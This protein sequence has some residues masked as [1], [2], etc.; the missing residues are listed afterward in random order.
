MGGND[1]QLGEARPDPGG[2]VLKLRLVSIMGG[3][4]VKRGR[5]SERR[6]AS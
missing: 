1:L 4:S 3:V 5:K 6:G 2:P